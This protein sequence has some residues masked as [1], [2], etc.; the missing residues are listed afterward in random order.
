MRVINPKQR[1]LMKKRKP[2]PKKWPM[3]LVVILVLLGVGVVANSKFS[4]NPEAQVNSWP[5]SAE[6]ADQL[7]TPKP[8]SG[9]LKT[10]TAEEFKDLYHQFAYPNTAPINENTPITG[11]EAADKR[12]KQ[13]AVQRGYK[14]RSAPVA[15]VFINVGGGHELQQKAAHPWLELKAAA[16]KEGIKLGLTSAYRSAEEQKQ[17][18]L[19]R[20][21]ATGATNS[22]IA[23]GHNDAQIAQVLSMTAPPGYSRHHTGYTVDISCENQPGAT[24]ETTSCYRWLSNNNYENA[25]TYGWIPGYPKGA[26]LQGPE[27]EAWEYVW[28][29]KEALTE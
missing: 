5:Q 15:N 6:K 12:I 10:F 16:K 13:I 19:Q 26:S 28:V 27:P 23:A 11:S 8:K 14:I 22:G 17:I 25:K 1:E 20:L 21:Y 29:G 3:V 18:F 2:K 24:F 9:K 7:P 4:R